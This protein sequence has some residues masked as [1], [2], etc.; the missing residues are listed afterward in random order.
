[1]AVKGPAR[2]IAQ[3]WVYLRSNLSIFRAVY[4]LAQS[5]QGQINPETLAGVQR[6]ELFMSP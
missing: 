1:M 6:L 3:H 4:F 2:K 5:L